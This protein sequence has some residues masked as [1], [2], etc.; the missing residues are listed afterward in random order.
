MEHLS[1]LGLKKGL[2]LKIRYCHSTWWRTQFVH[3]WA[4]DVSTC[5][6]LSKELKWQQAMELKT[7]LVGMSRSGGYFKV[8]K[9]LL[10]RKIWSHYGEFLGFDLVGEYIIGRLS[11]TLM[12]SKKGYTWT[13]QVGS[14][15]NEILS[16]DERKRE[17]SRIIESISSSKITVQN[18]FRQW[19]VNTRKVGIFFYIVSS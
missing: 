14:R 3:N 10:R 2:G 18:P 13:L 16:R 17:N 7:I 5:V 15:S 9:T 1:S 8:R 19:M 4:A 12:A 11:E 6:K